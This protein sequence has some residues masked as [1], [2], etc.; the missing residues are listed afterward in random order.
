[1]WKLFWFHNISQMDNQQTAKSKEMQ[2]YTSLSVSRKFFLCNVS[3]Q[4][5]LFPTITKTSKGVIVA[6]NCGHSLTDITVLC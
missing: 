5:N 3:I 6:G 2:I 4:R 1:M